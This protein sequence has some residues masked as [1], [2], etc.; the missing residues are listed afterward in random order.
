MMLRIEAGDSAKRSD[1][2]SVREETGRPVSTWTR[3][4]SFEGSRGCECRV[5]ALAV[6]SSRVL[7]IRRPRNAGSRLGSRGSRAETSRARS[8]GLVGPGRAGR[9]FAR[10]WRSAGGRLLWVLARDPAVRRGR[11]RRPRSRP[12]A[13][14]ACPTATSSSSRCPTTRSLRSREPRRPAS[15]AAY[16]FHVSGAVGSEAIAPLRAAG[17]RIGVSAPRSALHR[18]R[19]ERLARRVRRRRRGRRRRR[20]KP[21]GS[22]RR[23]GAHG[24][25]ARRDRS[26]L[27]HASATLAAGGTAALVSIAARGWAA[28]GIPEDVARETLGALASRAAAAAASRPFAE[29][30]TGRRRAPRRRDGARHVAALGASSRNA[31]ALPRR[32]P[33]KR[34]DGPPRPGR[35]TRSGDPSRTTKIRAEGVAAPRNPFRVLQFLQP[36]VC[37][38]ANQTHGFLQLRHDADGGQDRVLRPGPVRK[39]HQPPPHL[40]PDL[41]RLPRRDGLP[42]DGDG[43]DALLRSAAPGRRG[44]RRVQ[45]ADPALHGAGPGFLQ[46]DPQARPEG[47]RRDRLRRRFPARDEG[48]QHR[49]R[50]TTC[51]RTSA[52]IGI[53][54]DE[55]PLVFQYNKRDLS[56][57]LSVDELEESLNPERQYES[58]EACAVLGQGVFETL[59]AISRLTLRSLKKRMLGEEKPAPAAKAAPARR[60][61]PRSARAAQPAATAIRRRAPAPAP[62]AAT[63]RRTR[64]PPRSRKPSRSSPA[65]SPKAARADSARPRAQSA[66]RDVRRGRRET[67]QEFEQALDSL[68]APLPEQPA[69]AAAPWRPPR[70]A[71]DR[72]RVVRRGRRA[73]AREGR[74]GRGPARASRLQHRHPGR[75][76]EAAEDVDHDG[77]R[78]RREA[79]ASGPRGSPS[80]ICSRGASTTARRSARS[81]RS[82][83]RASSSRR[84]TRSRSACASR[85]SGQEIGEEKNFAIELHVAQRHP[86]APSLAQVP[87]PRQVTAPPHAARSSRAASTTRSLKCARALSSAGRHEALAAKR[88]CVLS[89]RRFNLSVHAFGPRAEASGSPR[90]W[91]AHW[92][93][94]MCDRPEDHRRRGRRLRPRRTRRSRRPA[95][96]SS[97]ARRPPSPGD[98]DCARLY[99]G[100]TPSTPCVLPAEARRPMIVLAFSVRA[101]GRHPALRGAR[102]RDRGSRNLARPDRARARSDRDSGHDAGGDLGGPRQVATRAERRRP[103]CPSSS[104]NPCCGSSPSSRARPPRRD[105]RGPVPLRP[106]RPDDPAVFAEEGLPQDLA[107]IALIESSFLPHARSPARPRASGSSCRAPAASTA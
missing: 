61:P 3:M 99:F 47:R 84:V 83:S 52:E 13:T 72:R 98:F 93:S 42:R 15:P 80:T 21:S 101:L 39:D 35:R 36:P 100:P 41:P 77:G 65:R 14:P 89:R 29:A 54:L 5:R 53:K 81:S 75:A 68:D 78:G 103:T 107:W 102:R 62:D 92:C 37:P 16:A 66:A 82:R 44:D 73:G 33:R 50:S 49:D 56:N 51:G 22:L 86:E 74:D 63:R 64:R 67:V 97:S 57:I 55:I 76:R 38:A 8:L 10:S 32:S 24:L 71:G 96:P 4:I 70:P 20:P 58:Y 30:F 48:R 85:T 69:A 6:S 43:P 87:H 1:L 27:Y 46:H 2:K 23:V 88:L 90:A 26:A 28:A 40:R 11:R 79:E 9:A 18:R 31:G 25:P 17:A 12:R 59:K 91:R 105:R 60:P 7:M 95:A 94:G 104:T 19:P 45:D 106:L 34:C